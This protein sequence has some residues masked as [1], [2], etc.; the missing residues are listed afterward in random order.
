MSVKKMKNASRTLDPIEENHGQSHHFDFLIFCGFGRGVFA[1]L[2]W[3]LII[4][5]E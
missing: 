2:D 3:R 1:L 4:G 5:K